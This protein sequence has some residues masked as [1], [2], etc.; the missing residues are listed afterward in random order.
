MI[1]RW[2]RKTSKLLVW[3][4]GLVRPGEEVAEEGKVAEEEV[5]EEEEEDNVNQLA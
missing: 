3:V 4:S 1:H 5:E 2:L